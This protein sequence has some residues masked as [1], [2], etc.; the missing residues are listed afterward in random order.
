MAYSLSPPNTIDSSPRFIARPLGPVPINP[1]T[2]GRRDPSSNYSGRAARQLAPD[3]GPEGDY[4]SS[5]T[6]LRNVGLG[7]SDTSSR[8]I[9]NSSPAADDPTAVPTAI[10]PPGG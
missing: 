5:Y 1:S 9:G 6:K 7:W 8:Y 10:E 2:L 4:R 3:K